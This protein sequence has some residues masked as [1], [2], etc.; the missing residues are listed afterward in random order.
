MAAPRSILLALAV[1][2]ATGA[3]VASALAAPALRSIVVPHRA[4]YEIGLLRADDGSGVSSAAGLMVFEVT[5]SACAGYS[6][7]QRMVINIGDEDG[8]LGKLDFRIETFESGDGDLYSFD[9]RTT[10]NEELIEAVE[11]EARRLGA[12][13]EVT[14]ARPAA[15]T[16][17]LDGAVLFPSQHLQAILDAALAE[18]S[19]LSVDIY[20]GVGSGE[21]SDEAIAAIGKSSKT[22]RDDPLGGDAR[23]WPVSIGYFETDDVAEQQASEELPAYQMSFTLFENGVTSDLVMDYGDYALSGALTEIEA[24]ASPGC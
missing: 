22:L 21:T 2:G 18:R 10:M 4:V 3:P 17:T 1:I 15:K 23:Q 24:L 14:L 19:Y 5:G 12:S 9:S 6:M 11:G 20:E 8:N 7:R 16:L 13:I